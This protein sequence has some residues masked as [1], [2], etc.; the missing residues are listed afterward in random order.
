MHASPP[1][2]PGSR[3]TCRLMDMRAG[4]MCRRG[5]DRIHSQNQFSFLRGDT[6]PREPRG[7]PLSSLELR[8][9]HCSLRRCRGARGS[10]AAWTQ[11]C[12]SF[13]WRRD[14][15]QRKQSPAWPRRKPRAG[16]GPLDGVSHRS[17]TLATPTSLEGVCVCRGHRPHLRRGPGRHETLLGTHRKQK[18]MAPVTFRDIH[19]VLA[20]LQMLLVK[21]QV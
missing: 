19:R 18:L 9:H 12:P 3:P 5:G 1:A 10:S 15:G 2:S 20:R 17:M 13:F 21:G 11:G 6:A 4:C 7:S 16:R 8:T 14:S